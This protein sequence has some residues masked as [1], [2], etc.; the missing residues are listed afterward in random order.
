MGSVAHFVS[1]H[2]AVDYQLPFDCTR[3]WPFMKVTPAHALVRNDAL[4]S[5]E[6]TCSRS[7]ATTVFVCQL[8][9]SLWVY[10]SEM[11]PKNRLRCS[12]YQYCCCL[13]EVRVVESL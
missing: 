12:M 6:T 4:S 11:Y 2:Q 9:F 13:H 1:C 5:V 10:L 7:G 3:I 8:P